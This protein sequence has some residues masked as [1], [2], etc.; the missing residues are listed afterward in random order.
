[1]SIFLFP[2]SGSTPK[3]SFLPKI[4]SFVQKAVLLSAN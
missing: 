3:A 4:A 1:M 2:S